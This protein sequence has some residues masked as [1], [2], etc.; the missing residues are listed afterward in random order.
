MASTPGWVADELV[1][2]AQAAGDDDAAV[3]G[4][5]FAD[6]LEAFLLGAVEEAAGVDE[7]DI[8]AGIVGRKAV[9]L[10]AQLG[11]DAFAIDQRFGAAEADE[12]NFWRLAHVSECS[13]DREWLGASYRKLDGYAM[14]LPTA[15]RGAGLFAMGGG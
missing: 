1:L 11:H 12:A 8:G 5:R 7:H 6:G 14:E 2:D 9:A 4:H 3:L 10:G 13:D 15:R